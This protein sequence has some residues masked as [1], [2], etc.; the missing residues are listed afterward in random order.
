[1]AAELLSALFYFKVSTDLSSFL[2]N[3]ILNQN[4]KTM[5]YKKVAGLLIKFVLLIISQNNWPVSSF[6][7]TIWKNILS[8]WNQILENF[9]EYICSQLNYKLV[10]Y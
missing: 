7:T 9:P 3:I 4:I 10:F 8:S 1:M 5:I 2:W 6:Y